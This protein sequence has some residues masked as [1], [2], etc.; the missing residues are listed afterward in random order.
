MLEVDNRGELTGKYVNVLHTQEKGSD[1]NLASELLLGAF[2]N[3]YD[4]AVVLSNDSDL[5]MPIKIIRKE[6]SKKVMVLNAHKKNPSSILSKNSDF[7]YSLT[8]RDY[9]ESQFS[10]TLTD[11]IGRFKK[12]DSW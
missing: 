3:E 12:P 2:K 8:V 5:L 7:F 9:A 11:L 6:F 1:V 10:E 4:L